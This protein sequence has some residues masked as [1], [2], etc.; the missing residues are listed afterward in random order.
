MLGTGP[1]ETG[2][3][4]LP[5][6]VGVVAGSMLAVKLSHRVAPRA[7][8]VTGGL[9]TA[10]GYSGY[11]F[12]SADRSYAEGILLPLVI[13]SVG[14][15]LCLAPA[16]LGRDGRRRATGDRRRIGPA[17]QLPPDWRSARPPRPWGTAAYHRTGHLTTPA[18][19][20]R[21]YALG[22]TL[23]AALLVVAVVVALTVLRRPTRKRIRLTSDRMISTEDTELEGRAL[24]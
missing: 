17:E 13:S 5:F 14:Y 24:S 6:A 22:L 1:A 16:G 11:A 15:G 7:L 19:L 9:I 18:A 12:I 3:Q 10:L 20:T 8:L 23:D 21:G 4:S 2:L